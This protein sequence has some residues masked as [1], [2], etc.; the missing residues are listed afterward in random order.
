MSQKKNFEKF[1]REAGETHPISAIHD[2][3]T[4]R[5]VDKY[6]LATC[7]IRRTIFSI[8]IF[9]RETL[10]RYERKKEREREMHIYLLNNEYHS[11]PFSSF[12]KSLLIFKLSVAVVRGG[13]TLTH[14]QIRVDG[15][16]SRVRVVSCRSEAIDGGVL[17]LYPSEFVVIVITLPQAPSHPLPLQF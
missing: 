14:T 8:R 6:I 15:L 11:L 10:M 4:S 12:L 3:S 13:A 9:S 2:V 7:H 1:K 16:R 5:H 17:P